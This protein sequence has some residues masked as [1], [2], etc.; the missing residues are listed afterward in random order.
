MGGAGRRQSVTAPTLEEHCI[1]ARDWQVSGRTVIT[2]LP[3]STTAVL[4][5]P[6]NTTVLHETLSPAAAAMKS[7]DPGCLSHTSPVSIWIVPVCAKAAKAAAV[8]SNTTS[9]KFFI[10]LPFP[11]KPP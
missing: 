2:V 3:I 1:F 5:K 10:P 4:L 9:I 11:Y 7:F 8:N 6:V